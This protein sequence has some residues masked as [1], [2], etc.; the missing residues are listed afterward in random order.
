[1]LVVSGFLI[2]AA[3]SVFLLFLEQGTPLWVTALILSGRAVAIGFVT[4]PLLIAMLAPLREDELADGNTLF[5]IT[6]RLG[7]SIGVS[8]LGSIVAGGVTLEATIDSFH[9][10]GAILIGLAL[11]GAVL[12]LWLTQGR[13]AAVPLVSTVAE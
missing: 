12:A 10:V 1:V 3:S 13:D 2:L 9:F 11:T 4:T 7:G 5:N 6:Q 8:I